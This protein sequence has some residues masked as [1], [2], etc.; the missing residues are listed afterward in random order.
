ML[1]P[2][3]RLLYLVEQDGEEAE[4]TTD[5]APATGINIVLNWFDEL[6]RLA[7]PDR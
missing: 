2:D 1:L 5:D 6:R 7:P 3:G 4:E